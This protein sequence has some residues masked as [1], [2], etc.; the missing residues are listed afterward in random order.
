MDIYSSRWRSDAGILA[1]DGESGGHD[2][3]DP[4]RGSGVT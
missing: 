2:L 1:P 4:D 3:A